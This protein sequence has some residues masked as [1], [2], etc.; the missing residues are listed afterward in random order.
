VAVVGAYVVAARITPADDTYP[1]AS[2]GDAE[3][4]GRPG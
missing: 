2:T 1:V 3:V 4:S